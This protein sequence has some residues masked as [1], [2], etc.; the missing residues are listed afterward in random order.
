MA[1]PLSRKPTRPSR[2]RGTRARGTFGAR[3][4]TGAACRDVDGR[5]DIDGA[6][7]AEEAMRPTDRRTRA[8]QLG[9]C[10]AGARGIEHIRGRVR[11]ARSG[12]RGFTRAHLVVRDVDGAAAA[13]EAMRP[14]TI[15]ERVRATPKLRGLARAA[16]STFGDAC[17][18]HV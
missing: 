13:E 15:A 12:P 2:V 7:A 14:T 1:V 5:R 10:A 8:R 11:L 3:G 4:F 17:V 16:S 9:G 6:A 18:W